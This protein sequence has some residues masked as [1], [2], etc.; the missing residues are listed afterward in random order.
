ME[1]RKE[2][3]TAH[4]SALALPVCNKSRPHS[5][6][7]KISTTL[8][9]YIPPHGDANTEL[10][11]LD[12]SKSTTHVSPAEPSAK[13]APSIV[14]L[15]GWA[16][17]PLPATG[18]FA[19]GYASLFPKSRILIVLSTPTILFFQTDQ[20]AQE[21]M[22]P[23][24]K[25]LSGLKTASNSVIISGPRDRIPTDIPSVILHAFSNGGL[26]SLRALSLAWRTSLS[27]PLPHA[28]LVLDSCP[29]SGCFN[30]E[31]F[32]WAE[33]ATAPFLTGDSIASKVP[34]AKFLMNLAALAWVTTAVRAPEI[35]TGRENLISAARRCVNDAQLLDPRGSVIYIYSTGDDAVRWQDVEASI[36]EM[37][38]KNGDRSITTIKLEKS[39]HVAH[40]KVY[41]E[42]YW[43]EVKN[44]W[45]KSLSPGRIWQSRS[46]L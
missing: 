15:F 45:E 40:E 9:E 38:N 5:Q 19:R 28:L 14:V 2:S 22:K 42:L 43:L 35:I 37:R 13:A 34:G 1:R 29:G 26:I 31:A 10:H 8:Y 39:N 30:T 4:S 25:E 23:L 20:S 7:L 33:S 36:E 41:R 6:F 24:L 17:A 32:R 46:K 21:S 11:S 27:S 3:S 16:S 44:A 12:S 18:R